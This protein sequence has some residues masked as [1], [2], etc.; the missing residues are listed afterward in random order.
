M[1]KDRTLRDFITDL[2][3]IA[4]EEQLDMPLRSIGA[5]NT[6]YWHVYIGESSLNDRTEIKIPIYKE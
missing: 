4:T 3:K 6:G 2:Q 5:G 1:L